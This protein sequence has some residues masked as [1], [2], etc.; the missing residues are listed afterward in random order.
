MSTKLSL[1]DVDRPRDRHRYCLLRTS[2]ISKYVVNG[3]YELEIVDTD[4]NPEYLKEIKLD[5]YIQSKLEKNLVFEAG[6]LSILPTVVSKNTVSPT[7]TCY[8]S[9]IIMTGKDN[10]TWKYIVCLTTTLDN[11]V[12]NLYVLNWS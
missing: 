1:T 4:M 9:S 11:E 8:F 5:Q 7:T 3:N 2:H 10:K 12:I 6:S